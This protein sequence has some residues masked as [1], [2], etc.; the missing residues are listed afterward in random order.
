M[1]FD[2]FKKKSEMS[3]EMHIRCLKKELQDNK[4]NIERLT[5]EINDLHNDNEIILKQ[6][7]SWK[8]YNPEFFV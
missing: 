6:L 8:K 2:E 1:N 5:S 3:P 7:E 4:R